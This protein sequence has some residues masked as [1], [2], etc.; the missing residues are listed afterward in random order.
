MN[1]QN[2]KLEKIKKS[3][4]VALIVTRIGKI[5]MIAMAVIVCLCGIGCIAADVLG[6]E[7]LYEEIGRA[8]PEEFMMTV[9]MQLFGFD[10]KV[11]DVISTIDIGWLG[12][13]GAYLIGLCVLLVFFAVMLH[14]VA[15]TFREIRDSDSPFRPVILKNLSLPFILITLLALMESL[16]FGAVVGIAFWCVYCILDYGCELQR[17]SDETL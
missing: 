17:Q 4:N 6:G 8:A 5:F 2:N 15:K 13:L 1:E 10:I 12:E 3:S 14:L 7:R 16:F 11:S 9:N